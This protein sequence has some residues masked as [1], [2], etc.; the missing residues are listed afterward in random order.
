MKRLLIAVVLPMVVAAQGVGLKHFIEHAQKENGQIRAKEIR[1][2]AKQKSV[3][4]A[5]SAFWPT[6][7]I[8]GSLSKYSPGYVVSPGEETTGYAALHLEVYDGG[9]KSATLRAKSFEKEAS[10]FEKQAFKKSVTLQIVQHYFGIKGREASLHALRER[11]KELKAQIARVRKFLATG[12][13][14]QE[15]LD[16]LLAVYENNRY[17]MEST[18]LAIETAKENLRLIT[19]I[20]AAHLGR[21]HFREPGSVKFEWFDVIKTLEANVRAVGE[22]AKAIDADNMPQVILSDTYFR[23]N[24]GDTVS[25]PPLPGMSGDGFLVDHQ[26]ELKLSV[27]MRLFDHGRVSKESESV[28]YQKLALLSELDH[29]KREQKMNFRLAKEG[30]RT[31]KAKIRSAK[32]ALKAAES[33]YRTIRKKFEA[34]LVDDIAYLDAL[35]QKTL[36]QA[37]YE[38]TVYDYEVKKSIYYYYAGKDPKEFIR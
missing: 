14:T 15:E 4:A 26:N 24:F 23:S 16:K 28:R 9:R 20:S 10:L 18:K 8:G 33:T 3:E 31:T 5:Q 38:E 22:R 35:A 19:G 32:S 6:V 37:R 30:L 21:D 11:A 12:L 17:T 13:T 29:A 2:T 25:M 34:G 1:I 7:D 36:A 27:N